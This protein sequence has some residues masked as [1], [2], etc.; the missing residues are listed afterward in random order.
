MSLF[1]LLANRREQQQLA[2]GSAVVF[3][4]LLFVS[5]IIIGPEIIA[6]TLDTDIATAKGIFIV[7]LF[8]TLHYVASHQARHHSI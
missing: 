8:G 3:G 5:L 1:F 7:L 6:N 4:F 2:E